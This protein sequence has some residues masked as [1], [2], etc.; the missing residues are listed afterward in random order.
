[1]TP[2]RATASTAPAS[3][4]CIAGGELGLRSAWHSAAVAA[5][6]QAASRL[7][8]LVLFHAAGLERDGARRRRLLAECRD[9]VLAAESWG[10]RA[11]AFLRAAGGV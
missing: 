8:A 5:G 11:A 4:R 7:S 2:E 3:A 1:M 9:E 10:E 6:M